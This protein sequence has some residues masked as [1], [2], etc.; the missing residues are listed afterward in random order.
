MPKHP[1]SAVV[2]SREGGKMWVGRHQRERLAS[3]VGQT[4]RGEDQ[5]HEDGREGCT[6]DPR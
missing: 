5:H 3:E 2:L 6:A 4:R 1:A